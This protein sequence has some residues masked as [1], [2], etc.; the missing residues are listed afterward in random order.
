MLRRLA[1]L[2]LATTGLLGPYREG[3]ADGWDDIARE[4]ASRHVGIVYSQAHHAVPVSV[5]VDFIGLEIAIEF[6]M[7]VWAGTGSIILSGP[8]GSRS[9]FRGDK[10]PG[11]EGVT[12]K[13]VEQNA[14]I[15]EYAGE[16]R[17]VSFP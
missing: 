8:E 11:F 14:V 4:L 1:L 2:S 15:Y 16:E 6:D 10:V 3:R 7:G 12:V 13:R 17:R 9:L 5:G